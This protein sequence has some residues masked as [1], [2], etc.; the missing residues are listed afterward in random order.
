[1]TNRKTSARIWFAAFIGGLLVCVAAFP[2]DNVPQALGSD[3]PAVESDAPPQPLQS[4]LKVGEKVASFYV[5]A[6]TGPLKNKSVCY[7]CRHGD[8]PVV[9][10]VIRRIT[11]ELKTL[12]KRIDAEI[13]RHRAEG[14]RGFGVFVGEENQTLLPQVQTLAFDAGIELPLTIAAAPADGSAAGSVHLDAAVTL[15]LYKD[16]TVKANFAYRANELNQEQIERV[17]SAIRRLATDD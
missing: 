11:P 12:L 9:M 14:L 15:L 8:R 10:I 2:V 3:K 7:V 13:D 5:R 6:V 4:G 16:L 17:I 1:M